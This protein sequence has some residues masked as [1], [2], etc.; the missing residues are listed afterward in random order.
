MKKETKF[1]RLLLKIQTACGWILA[2]SM[3]ILAIIMA[4]S[5]PVQT[6]L[7]GLI[8][9]GICPGVDLPDLV[10]VIVAVVA[11]VALSV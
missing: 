7:F 1:M 10:R 8:A 4:F 3:G 11:L 9:I 5:F 2:V 6:C